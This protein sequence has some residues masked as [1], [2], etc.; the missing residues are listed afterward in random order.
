MGTSYTVPIGQWSI[1]DYASATN[2]QDD[3]AVMVATGAP[4]R[5]DDHPNGMSGA[6]PLGT[7]SSAYRDGV[8]TQRSDTDFFVVQTSCT[9]TLTASATPAAV[10]PNWISSCAC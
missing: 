8:I 3:L 6:T 7:G 1:G 5:T 10:A 9:G 4:L 2:A